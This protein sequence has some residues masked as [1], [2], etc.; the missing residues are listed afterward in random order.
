VVDKVLATDEEYTNADPERR[1]WFAYI[2]AR[3]NKAVLDDREQ[4]DAWTQE[5]EERESAAAANGGEDYEPTTRQELM[6]T[7]EDWQAT[8]HRVQGWAEEVKARYDRMLS[9]PPYAQLRW[10]AKTKVG[11]RLRNERRKRRRR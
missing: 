1:T 3:P 8:A 10:A 9:L 4:L 6:L 7:S 2:V 11:E 5:E